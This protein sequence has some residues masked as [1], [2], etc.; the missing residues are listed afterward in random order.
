MWKQATSYKIMTAKISHT[1]RHYIDMRTVNKAPV[2]SH[3]PVEEK[4]HIRGDISTRYKIGLLLV[5]ESLPRHQRAMRHHR[6]RP[7]D[8]K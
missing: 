8:S 4:I 5:C 6:H 7:W 2:N 3:T 1:S